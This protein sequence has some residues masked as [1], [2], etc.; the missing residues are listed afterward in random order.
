[1][2]LTTHNKQMNNINFSK[3]LTAVAAVSSVALT[4]GALSLATPAPE[5]KAGSWGGNFNGTNVRV[6][7]GGVRSGFSTFSW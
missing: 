1:M 2:S 3:V 5:A 4:A 7:G 6:T